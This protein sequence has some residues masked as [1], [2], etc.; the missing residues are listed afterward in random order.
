MR[1]T[2]LDEARA[3]LRSAEPVERLIITGGEPTSRSDL[4][5]LCGEARRLG[6]RAIQ[7]QTHGG[8]LADPAFARAL[9]DAGVDAVDVPL[10]GARPTPHDQVTG[11][12]GSFLRALAGA[13]QAREAG[14]E[15]A[16]HS[17]VFRRTLSEVPG[18]LRLAVD[19]GARH[20]S[21]EPVGLIDSLAAYER[22]APGLAELGDAMASALERDSAGP[23]EVSTAAIPI[24]ALPASARGLR[25]ERPLLPKQ[26][27]AAGY[28]DILEAI[29][30]GASR[31]F[32]S[33]CATCA[34]RP[35]CRGVAAETLRLLGDGA[36]PPRRA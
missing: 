26:A 10:Y 17:T 8:R 23:M 29:T 33:A 27:V 30:G 6:Y 32:G 4:P 25:L 16:V 13:R 1:P 7:L 3:L 2:S 21:L 15:L 22:E 12:A 24:C 35:G 5:E 18:L 19:L 14:M 28:A 36:L 9:K 34:W 31:D 11:V 20:F